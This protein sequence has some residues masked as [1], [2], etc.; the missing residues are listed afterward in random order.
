[1]ARYQNSA[2]SVQ[3]YFNAIWFVRTTNTTILFRACSVDDLSVGI[4]G[5]RNGLPICKL[6]ILNGKKKIG[7]FYKWVLI[8]DGNFLGI[9]LFYI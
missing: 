2:W 1:M 4:H 7:K 6:K 5:D 8:I 9:F 3:Y